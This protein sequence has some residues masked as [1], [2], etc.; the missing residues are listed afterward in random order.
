MKLTDN[1][2]S[3]DRRRHSSDTLVS[4]GLVFCTVSQSTTAKSRETESLIWVPYSYRSLG[5]LVVSRE[6]PCLDG[7]SRSSQKKQGEGFPAPSSACGLYLGIDLREWEP[8]STQ[9]VCGSM[10]SPPTLL[11]AVSRSS[12]IVPHNSKK[13]DGTSSPGHSPRHSRVDDSL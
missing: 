4:G 5:N 2:N 1:R 6:V 8:N 12:L 13:L 11:S 9:G 7:L 3:Q 10:S